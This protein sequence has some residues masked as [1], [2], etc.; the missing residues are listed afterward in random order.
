[1]MRHNSHSYVGN[2]AR[3]NWKAKVLL[4]SGYADLN[5]GRPVGSKAYSLRLALP[6]FFDGAVS[7]ELAASYRLQSRNRVT[8]TR[9]GSALRSHAFRDFSKR[10]F[11]LLQVL[12]ELHKAPGI[13]RFDHLKRIRIFKEVREVRR[14]MA[15]QGL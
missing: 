15:L 8:Q 3:P 5:K 6:F 14:H 13:S 10:F 7:N 9:L 2:V 11:L 4:Y 12:S 1:M